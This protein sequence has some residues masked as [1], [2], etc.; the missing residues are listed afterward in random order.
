MN[1]KGQLEIFVIVVFIIVVGIITYPWFIPK[2]TGDVTKNFQN[3]LTGLIIINKE[4]CLNQKD[5]GGLFSSSVKCK[6]EVKNLDNRPVEV[7]P[8]FQCYKLSSPLVKEDILSSRDAI[9][10]LS[11]KFFEISY[12]NNGREWSCEIVNFNAK[13]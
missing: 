3:N 10:S 9:P 1:K 4:D 5:S 11:S 7:I 12:N 13:Y 8:L 2:S 6:L